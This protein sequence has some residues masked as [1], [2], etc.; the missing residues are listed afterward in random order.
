LTRRRERQL[1]GDAADLFAHHGESAS[2]LLTASIPDPD[3]SPAERRRHRPPGS[4]W[5]G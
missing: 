1:I 3:L 2:E 4:K 5:S